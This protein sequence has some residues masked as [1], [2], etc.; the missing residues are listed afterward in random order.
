MAQRVIRN[1]AE[2]KTYDEALG[3]YTISK[4]SLESRFPDWKKKDEL[5]NNWLSEAKEDWPYDSLVFD[6]RVWTFI[7][8]KSSRLIGSKPKG[9]LTPREN[10][11]E[12]GA[13]INNSLLDFYWDDVVRVENEPMVSRWIRMDQNTRR[14]GA[15]FGLVPWHYQTQV[16]RKS[17]KRKIFYDGPNFIPWNPRDVLAN[18][19]YS[20]IK[21]WIQ[22]RKYTTL[23]EL[24]AVND[25]AKT[26]PVYKNLDKLRES[27]RK[28][29]KGGGD[30]RSVNYSPRYLEIKG[31]NDYL[32]RDE[33][34]RVV[35]LITEYRQ[36]RWITFAPR[37]GLILR[38]VPNP[39]DHGQI[40]VVKL[41]YY[42]Q[43]DD[44]YGMSEIEPVEKLQNGA[45]A[46]I[47][48][49]LDT[50]NVNLYPPLLVD[51]TKMRMHTIEFGPR[52]KWIGTP[53]Q[54]GWASAIDKMESGT[55]A[56]SQFVQ[57]YSF[58]ISAIMNALGESSLGV[59]NLPSRFQGDKTATEVKAVEN[60]RSS[61]DNFNLIYLSE[62]LKQQMQFWHL[63]SKQFVFSDPSEKSKIIRIVGDDA[64]RFF[65]K[66]GLDGVSPTE[67]EIIALQESGAEV[68][69]VSFSHPVEVGGK[70]TGKFMLD[71]M[72]KSGQL[73]LEP[74]DLSGTYDYIPDI[75]SWR[76]PSDAEIEAKLQAL[77]GLVVNP[78]FQQ[79]L[80]AEGKRV[81]VSE[82]FKKVVEFSKISKDAESL[83]EDL[84]EGGA[85]NGQVIGGG[86]GGFEGSF[87]S[88]GGPQLGGVAQS[89]QALPNGAF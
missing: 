86:G 76:I 4:E 37:H 23:Q 77:V 2:D 21:N 33:T 19:A 73:A 71:R 67:E 12:L 51:P 78:S 1:S 7:I 27:L 87:G 18:P 41:K 82:V 40:P 26:G 13:E 48:Q 60:S 25:S 74:S 63:L 9:R 47:C 6:P 36:D 44:I 72:G 46:L 10:G 49:Y 11:D 22:L 8:D 5:F 75:E 70:T 17:G 58:M 68:P 42:W 3:H 59:S 14:Y 29:T 56:T 39:Y 32:G 89:P 62:A 88:Q 57:T 16:D 66:A 20:T 30:N 55:A 80:A 54:G 85:L 53:G 64:I 28:N 34:Y 24:E 45:N 69:P 52:K 15:S 43:D 31:L 38:D 83:I 50:V 65:Q 35:E 81:K 79:G 84:P 61:R